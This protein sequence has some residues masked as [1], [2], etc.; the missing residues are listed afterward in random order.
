ELPRRSERKCAQQA[1]VRRLFC[2]EP[3]DRQRIGAE[4]SAYGLVHHLILDPTPVIRMRCSAATTA[5][6]GAAASGTVGIVAVAVGIGA[7]AAAAAAA[8]C[9]S[10]IRRG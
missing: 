8:A 1:I 2:D 4:Y 3:F 5:A 7:G 6:A 9:G 10:A